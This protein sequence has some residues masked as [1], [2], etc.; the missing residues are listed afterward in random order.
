M[1][2]HSRM[3][4]HTQPLIDQ[5]HSQRGGPLVAAGS[6]TLKPLL[7]HIWEPKTRRMHHVAD[8]NVTPALP[9]ARPV[10]LHQPEIKH[11]SSLTD[12]S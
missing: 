1:E 8:R 11:I 3:V 5:P 9:D 4:G 6:A 2:H 10:A 12:L 7:D